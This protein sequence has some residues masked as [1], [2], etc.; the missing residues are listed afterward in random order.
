MQPAG[1]VIEEYIFVARCAAERNGQGTACEV[2]QADTFPAPAIL[3][4]DEPN[5]MN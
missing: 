1:V 3:T 4:T 2:H 5:D